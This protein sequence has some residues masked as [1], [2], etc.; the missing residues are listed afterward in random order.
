VAPVPIGE[1]RDERDDRLVH[2]FLSVRGTEV[3]GRYTPR[4]TAMRCSSTAS[5]NSA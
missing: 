2:T 4:S 3:G 1:G 5:V